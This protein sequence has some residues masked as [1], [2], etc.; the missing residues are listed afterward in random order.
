M[1]KH[2]VEPGRSQMILWRMR[3]TCWKTKATNTHSE[4][5]VLFAFL[6]QQWLQERAS[7]LPYSKFACL[8][9]SYVKIGAMKFIF[10]V[11]V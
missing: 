10:Y 5:V 7:M 9:W 4:C 2:I 6:L 8:V 11:I 1:L 3:M